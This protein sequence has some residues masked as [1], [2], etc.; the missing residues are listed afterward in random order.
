MEKLSPLQ[1]D[2][3]SQKSKGVLYNF[4]PKIAFF[5]GMGSAIMLLFIIGFFILLGLFLKGASIGSQTR[6]NPSSLSVATRPS[7][8]DPSLQLP[9]A[10]IPPPSQPTGPVNVSVDDDAFLGK[11]NAP[12]TMIEFSDFQCPFCRS[13]WRETLPQIKKEYIDTG[14]VKFVY[15]DF[16]LSFHSGATP[17]A[18]GAECARD[19][20]KFWEMHD[21]IF[22]EQQKQG[23]GT[24]Q[25][26]A[27]DVKK[28]AANIG[29]NTT[30][31]NQCL[32]SGKYKQEVE[33]DIADGSAAGVSGTP[34]T[35]I[36]GRL[37]SGAYP[38]AAFKVIIDEELKKL[39]K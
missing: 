39:G 4:T 26:T 24:I 1:Q 3:N 27:D 19:Q 6:S 20:G 33:K 25:F 7:G 30:K 36:N 21:A 8:P 14:K 38:F 16:P 34:A 28:W 11:K 17:A 13:L 2:M 10:P 15:R 9:S 37:I 31:F 22:E 12:V 18:E 32:D 5:L 35:F 29:L 23:S